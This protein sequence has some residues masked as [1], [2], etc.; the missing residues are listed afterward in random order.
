VTESATRSRLQR[1]LAPRSIAFIGGRIAEMALARCLEAGF[2]GAIFAVHPTR[3]SV[4]GVRCYPSVE[5]LPVVPDAAYVGVNRH[6][7]LEVV[8][9]LAARGAG[10]C[11]CYA[12]GFAEVGAA[13]A[14]LQQQLVA[15]A[16]GMPVVGPNCFGLI[17]Y[18]DRCALWP[19]LFGGAPVT[20]G[21][22]LISQ[23]GNVA[24]NLTMNER[25][26]RFTHVICAG[27]QAVLGPADYLE[28]LLA[29]SRVRAVGML[30]EGLD[31]LN[32]FAVQARRAL[33]QGVP[34]V[35]MKVGR[36]AAGAARASSHT[37]S[38][39]GSDVLYDALF[40]RLGVIRVNSLTRLLETLKLFDVSG[41]LSGPDIVTLSCSGGEAAI[42]A[43]LCDQYGLR[44]PPFSAVQT[45]ALY[46]LFPG[47]VTV[48][49]PFDY[50]TSIWGDR[51]A[52]RRCFTI[53]LGGTHHA[54]VLVYDHPTVVADEVAEWIDALDAF[55]DAQRETG[56]RA[57]VACTIPELLPRELRER[58]IGA[59]IT[60][61]QGLEDGLFALAAA[62]AYAG[63]RESCQDLAL[64]RPA[65]QGCAQ[66]CGAL[67]DEWHSKQQLAAF[68]VRIPEGKR[69]SRGELPAAAATLG[70]PLALKAC[71]SAFAHK[72]E[73]GAVVAGIGDATALG[74]AADAIV[75][76]D[77]SH[78]LV[79]ESFLVERMIE[80]AVAELIV[81]V[82]ADAQ[83]GPTLLIGSGGILVELVGDAA[84][85]LL[86]VDR[87]SVEVALMS[88][89]VARLLR[90]FRGKGAGDV[91]ATV[92]AILAIAAF[93]EAHWSRLL[94]LDVNPLIVLPQ[95][96]GIVAVDALLSLSESK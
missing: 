71:G 46:R 64:P 40:R 32:A 69:V 47:Y 50:N 27:N 49:N 26:V 20:Q 52:M 75:A 14:A 94:E 29:D 19:Y 76:A 25:S 7:T 54:A 44:T 70:Y 2:D 72:S 24:M 67:L 59:G 61:L 41:P 78:G 17:N 63:V 73:L 88:L 39:A 22:A 11:V 6:A 55:I 87:A 80:G 45:D 33:R 16:D 93:A 9:S 95:G 92:D 91:A 85:L 48:S 10:G 86:P 83:F 65:P 15:A 60:P 79:V 3:E 4:R 37:S 96:Q 89:K 1:L 58:L 74:A 31:D 42:L 66:P 28:A 35:V 18:A 62:A 21:V 12:A 34:I 13:G 81:G 43:D 36:T 84:N 30:I 8:R 5:S 77:A 68:G 53:S 82:H 57:F 90:G 23:S 56:M 51:E 38:L